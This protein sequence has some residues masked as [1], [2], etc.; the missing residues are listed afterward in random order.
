MHVAMVLLTVPR[1]CSTHSGRVAEARRR[2]PNTY[3][4]AND[5]LHGAVRDQSFLRLS[6][7]WTWPVY[8][9][10]SSTSQLSC[11]Q[12]MCAGMY[13]MSGDAAMHVCETNFHSATASMKYHDGFCRYLCRPIGARDGHRS[14][15]S[16]LQA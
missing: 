11:A 9:S 7:A 15:Y 12:Q 3:K 14:G 4:M 2:T 10:I 1:R 8:Q 13:A 5:K 6:Y 16:V